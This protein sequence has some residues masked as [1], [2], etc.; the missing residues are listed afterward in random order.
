V[1]IWPALGFVALLATLA[2]S[3]LSDPR[4]QALRQL[5]KTLETIQ[6]QPS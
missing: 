1:L 2:A 4:P 5:A 3:S 6:D